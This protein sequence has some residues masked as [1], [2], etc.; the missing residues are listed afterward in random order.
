MYQLTDELVFPHPN[1]AN[2]NGILAWG[3]DLT[4]ER[5]ELAYNNGIFPWYN[6][7]EP[8][9]WWSPKQRFV[10]FPDELKI[11]KS[12]KKILRTGQ[13][14]VTM[15]K[16][17]T[18]VINNCKR[19]Y[20]SG[21]DDTWITDEMEQAYITLHK[22]GIAHSVEVWNNNNLAGGLYGVVV[23]NIFCGESMFSTLSNAS[24]T[25]FITLVQQSNYKLIDCQMH[26][27]HLESL[28]ARHIP[29]DDFLNYLGVSQ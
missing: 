24:K 11:S 23:K 19:I 13:F 9:V 15:D 4:P 1:L 12:M 3:G 28:G 10:L 6:K 17:F 16:D 20:R 14:K 8:I 26:T 2:K 5:L 18:S 25:G 29:R 21:Q 27:N 22:K 7:E